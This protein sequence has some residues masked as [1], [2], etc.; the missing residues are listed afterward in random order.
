M[1]RISLFIHNPTSVAPAINV[2]SVLRLEYLPIHQLLWGVLHQQIAQASLDRF[3]RRETTLALS[4]LHTP[5]PHENGCIS[6]AATQ[7]ARQCHIVIGVIIYLCG[8][9]RS[10]NP[11]VQ[12]PHWLPWWSIMHCCAG[13]GASGVE[14]PSIVRNA[15]FAIWGKNKIHA[16][17]A[18][19]PFSS[20]TITVQ[21]PQSPSLHPSFVPVRRLLRR[22]QSNTDVVGSTSSM[23]WGSPFRRNDNFMKLL[24]RG[25]ECSYNPTFDA[26]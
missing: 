17:T 13:C 23:T 12:N 21:A 25:T 7:I 2:V 8:N 3:D 18:R 19:A 11:G 16:L 20:I 9:H 26:A 6:C 15:L 24:H 14:I 5:V 10:I 1:S 22:N 4:F